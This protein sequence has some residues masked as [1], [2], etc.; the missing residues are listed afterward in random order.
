MTEQK[1]WTKDEIK[2]MIA[3]NDEWL[4][5]AI[6]AIYDR[7]TAQEQS[8]EVTVEHNGIGFN[9]VDAYIMSEFAK[10]IRQ[11]KPLTLKMRMLSRK[12]MVKY[13]GQLVKI[14]NK[15]V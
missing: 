14:A 6:L 5:H 4:E 9:G 2:G 7:Q 11:G 13:A 12:K 3:T 10:W 15:E 8:I 1:V